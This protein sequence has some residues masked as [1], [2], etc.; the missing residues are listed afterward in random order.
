MSL[1]LTDWIKDEV[2]S[3]AWKYMIKFDQYV[4]SSWKSIGVPEG[5]LLTY[6][7]RMMHDLLVDTYT[8]MNS[9][10]A[11]REST[12]QLWAACCYGLVLKYHVDVG[13]EFQW[14]NFLYKA[15]SK[16][17]AKSYFRKLEWRVYECLDFTIPRVEPKE[18]LNTL[19]MVRTPTW[20]ASRND[21][22][23]YV[24]YSTD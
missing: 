6:V 10:E 7:K 21:D 24:S 11:V 1:L 13:D 14:C 9:V 23:D 3:K 19:M 8:K 12:L 18:V 5:Y 20:K 17:V 16:Q 15:M 4:L 2:G 22:E